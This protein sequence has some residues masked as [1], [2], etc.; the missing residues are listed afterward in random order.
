MNVTCV[1]LAY[2]WTLSSSHQTQQ[3]DKPRLSMRRLKL[4]EVML[5]G[6]CRVCGRARI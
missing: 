2:A 1:S 3:V 6:Q 5:T 4:R